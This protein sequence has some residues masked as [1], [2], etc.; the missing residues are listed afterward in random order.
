GWGWYTG[1]INL[2]GQVAVTTAI[3]YGLATFV[4]ILMNT[5]WGTPQTANAIM[6]TFTVCLLLH[7]I[8]NALGVKLVALLN[9]ISVWWHIAV[10]AL[11]IA[12][13]VFK[14]PTHSLS[15]AFHTGYTTS[16]FPYW[17]G[18]LLG[19]LL[20]QYT[21]TGFDASAHMSEETIGA[22]SRA[23]WGI[24]MSVVISAIA[25]WALLLALAAAIP[26]VPVAKGFTDSIGTVAN[27]P[28]ANPVGLILN[29][30][31]GVRL[32]TFLLALAVVAQFYC[33]MSSVTSNSRMIYAFSRDGA[34]PLSKVWHALN[35][36]TRT[37]INAIFIGAF[38][39]WVLAL[40][41][42]WST[43]AYL[44]ATSIAVIGLFLAYIIPVYLRWRAGSAFVRGRWHLGKWSATVNVVAMLWVVF[45]C[46]LFML[47]TANPI[48]ST[49]FNYTP[50]VVLGT[51]AL[52]TLWYMLSVRH[53]FTG[54]KI[55][56]SAD[57]LAQIEHD[58][59]ED[60]VLTPS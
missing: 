53:W 4:N 21:I 20:A 26:S 42:L 52:L 49:N 6:I 27:A 36:R 31:L 23:P 40:P 12:F 9:D 41:S 14:A 39:S 37:P 45:I 3:D 28:G 2:I 60:V 44:A 18:F 16:G 33:G 32:G 46:I 25:G 34:L 43:T 57:Q 8:M 13:L 17:Y 55:Q 10:A 47:P 38:L 22:E 35:K 11:F 50:I 30:A 5:W 29:S 56:G 24:V 15:T 51:L 19:F 58:L 7:A 59:G 48:N 54:P 1:W